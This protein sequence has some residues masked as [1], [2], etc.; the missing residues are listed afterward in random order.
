[1][2]KRFALLRSVAILV[3]G[4]LL[5]CL[6]MTHTAVGAEFLPL[7][8]LPPLLEFVDGGSVE[9]AAQWPARKEEIRRLLMQYFTGSPPE[10]APAGVGGE[11]LE[12]R[13]ADDS[14]TRRRIRVTL[15]TP[16]RCSFE[17]WLWLPPGDGPFP[18][19]LT[20]PR[21]AGDQRS[22]VCLSWERR[23]L[24]GPAGCG[25]RRGNRT[26]HLYAFLSGPSLDAAF[27]AVQA[28]AS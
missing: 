21:S 19:L 3:A 1:M 10:A 7:A 12:E 6:S 14:S 25:L 4:G 5:P 28:N 15:A 17:M 16:N 20:A 26:G 9:R 2:T 27:F 18:L 24:V 22:D 23:C 8:D 11:V 13:I